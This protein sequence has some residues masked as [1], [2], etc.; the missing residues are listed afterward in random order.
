MRIS[1]LYYFHHDND[2]NDDNY[3]NDNYDNDNDN[4]DNYDNNNNNDL[5]F[6]NNMFSAEPTSDSLSNS[7]ID[8]IFIN[9]D[10]KQ[11]SMH[12]DLPMMVSERC[13]P[14]AT[15]NHMLQILRKH[16]HTYLPLDCRSLM[17]TPRNASEN[18]KLISAGKY[19]HF[20]FVPGIP[21][22]TDI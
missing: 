16:G 14:Q 1:I 13:I 4:D 20:G 3:D 11:T 7:I 9:N 5:I 17:S 15:V 8:E 2:N 22:N 21:A 12:E 6:L 19:K 10:F 18:I